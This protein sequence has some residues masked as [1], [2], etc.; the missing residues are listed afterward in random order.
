MNEDRKGG[1][2]VYKNWCYFTCSTCGYG[3]DKYGHKAILYPYCP[4]CGTKMEEVKTKNYNIF[5]Y[6][7]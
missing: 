5:E 7:E 6:E 3:I 1:E 2:W 4:M